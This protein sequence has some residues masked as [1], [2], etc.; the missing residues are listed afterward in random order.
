MLY[1]YYLLYNYY[2]LLYNYYYLIYFFNKIIFIYILLF[3]KKLKIK[4]S[5]LLCKRNRN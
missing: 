4:N 5:N 1:N 3:I 2:Y